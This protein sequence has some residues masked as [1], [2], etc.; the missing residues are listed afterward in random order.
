MKLVP[1]GQVTAAHGLRGE[2]RF[3]YYNEGGDAPLRYPSFFV[4]ANGAKLELR[5]AGIR[6]QKGRFIIKF[7]G[8]ESAE[9]VRFLLGKEIFVRESDLAPLAED[10]YY[11]YRLI[12]LEAVA[13]DGRSLGA[14]KDVMHTRANDILVVGNAPE[15][16]VPMTEDYIVKIDTEAGLV[17]VRGDG[18]NQ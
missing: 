5:P 13:E 9:A 7:E 4:D 11:D 15:V 17:R 1:V 10:E 2:V 12:G 6:T 14:V 16:L 3:R 18:I 8:L